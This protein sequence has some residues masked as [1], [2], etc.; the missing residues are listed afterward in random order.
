MISI[1]SFRE[2][3]KKQKILVVAGTIFYIGLVEVICKYN[4]FQYNCIMLLV[5]IC[6]LIFVIADMMPKK[7]YKIVCIFLATIS[8]AL[9]A[10]FYFRVSYRNALNTN[11]QVS[12]KNGYNTLTKNKG[13][14]LLSEVYEN[15]GSRYEQYGIGRQRNQSWL[16][17]ISGFDF[18]ISIYNNDIDKFHND[19]AFYTDSWTMGY[20]GLN[21]RLELDSLFGVNHYIVWNEYETPYGYENLDGELDEFSSYKPKIENSIIYGFDKSIGYS[22]F[23]KL[24]IIDR[25]QVIMKA[26]VVDDKEA[27]S[28]SDKIEFEREKDITIPYEVE[29]NNKSIKINKNGIKAEILDTE[30]NKIKLN[31]EPISESE[32]WAYIE[33]I[34]FYYNDTS[35]YYFTIENSNIKP[36][37]VMRMNNKNHMYGGKHNVIVNLGYFE[38]EINSLDFKFDTIGNYTI[39]N[40][41]LIKRPKESIDNNTAGLNRIA[42]K[43]KTSNNKISFKANLDKE[44]YVFISV[45]Y[46]SGWKA[47]VNGKTMKILKVDDAFMALKLDKGNYNIE[48]KYRT[49]GLIFGLVISTCSIIIFVVILKK[50]KDSC[51]KD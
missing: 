35:I 30:N 18:Y 28:K 10:S 7:Y 6:S 33:G 43:I 45:P 14:N 32:V 19:I 31:F 1:T 16:Y 11:G 46:S 3:T 37:K 9:P 23:E 24:S 44:Q 21:R 29:N 4:T 34:D 12:Y 48:L 40:I 25:N 17:G 15:D 42:K 39:K 38:D 41:K 26:L 20:H 50:S 36:Q 47:K 51:K 49:P 8:V 22:D 5:L 27:N 2:A 13:M